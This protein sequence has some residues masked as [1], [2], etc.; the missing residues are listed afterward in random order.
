L[1]EWKPD[2]QGLPGS[3]MSPGGKPDLKSVLRLY[4]FVFASLL[5]LGSYLQALHFEYGMIATQV[6]IILIPALLYWRRFALDQVTFARL[7]P[8]PL[9]FVPAIVILAAA[10][11]LVNVFIAAGLVGGLMEL[12]FKPLVVIEPPTTWQQYLGYIVVL[13]VFAGICEEVLFRGT[14]MPAL[15]QYGLVPAI[16]FSSLLFALLHGSLLSLISTFSL[17]V[18]MAV[19]VI[20]TGSLWGGIIY[21]MLNNFY[22]ATYLFWAGSMDAAPARFGLQTYLALLPFLVVGLIGVVIG[23]RMLHKNSDHPSLL[24]SR[25]AWLPA[26]WLSWPLSISIMLFI[27]I[28]ALEIAIGFSWLELP[29]TIMNY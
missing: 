12:G 4:L 7:R 17:G 26:G 5:L 20:K 18:I 27:I 10:M 6:L 13:S 29:D 22:A 2:K 28:A 11:W 24:G 15:E 9:K 3:L 16:I 8:L 19:I 25:K 14:I 1:A 21:H 23:L